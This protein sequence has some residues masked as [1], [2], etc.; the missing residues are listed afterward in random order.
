[1]Q[2]T[3]LV[4]HAPQQIQIRYTTP[5]TTLQMQQLM[6]MHVTLLLQVR[7]VT[8]RMRQCIA[9]HAMVMMMHMLS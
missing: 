1:M 5:D 9:M 3:Q 7:G 6:L 2:Q 8:P 4:P